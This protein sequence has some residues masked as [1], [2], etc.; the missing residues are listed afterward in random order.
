M[1]RIFAIPVDVEFT[2]DRRDERAA[3]LTEVVGPG[4]S[5]TVEA[6]RHGARFLESSF[7]QALTAPALIE[8]AV[9][10]EAEGYDAIA[11]LCMTDPFV[12]AMREAVNIPVVGSC[13]AS[14]FTAV[15]VGWRFSIVTITDGAIPVVDRAV[16]AAGVDPRA[17]T[18]IRSIDMPIADM[19]DHPSEVINRLTVEAQGAI[20][21]DGAKA[22]ILGCTEMGQN[23]APELS[24]RLGVPV[25]DPNV[26]AVQFAKS[27]VEMGY[28][29]SR[30][31][32]PRVPWS[33]EERVVT[34]T[35]V[36]RR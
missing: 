21:A 27:M 15:M 24:R 13:Q 8:L 16:V 19:V 7:D 6:P 31:T 4:N 2:D 35:V 10:A 32:Y 9:E 33:V 14:C 18:S 17:C 5:V 28:G 30:L 1:A 25:I 26:A 11:V 12:D 34:A 3:W 36:G 20:R 29:H 23:A 22:I